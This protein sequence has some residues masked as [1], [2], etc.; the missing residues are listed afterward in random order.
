MAIAEDTPELV[1]GAW[2]APLI[3]D[4]ADSLF[5]RERR[6][7]GHINQRLAA[8]PGAHIVESMPPPSAGLTIRQ[9]PLS[10]PPPPI[11]HRAKI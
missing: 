5:G 11:S 8:A 10:H 7:A 1:F 3:G 4:A 9:A 6:G 2:L